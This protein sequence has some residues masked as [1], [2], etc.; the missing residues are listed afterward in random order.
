MN[1]W[2]TLTWLTI[3]VWIV[4]DA[5]RWART[6]RRPSWTSTDTSLWA[7]IAVLLVLALMNETWLP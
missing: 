3:A 7:V 6:R 4:T 2:W 5:V 1:V